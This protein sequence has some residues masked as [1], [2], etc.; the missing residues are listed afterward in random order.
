[1]PIKTPH[2]DDYENQLY[3]GDRVKIG[4]LKGYYQVVWDDEFKIWRMKSQYCESG[5]A[6][7][8]PRYKIKKITKP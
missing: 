7:G 2:K 5:F 6:F 1:M 3:D 4:Q 8:V